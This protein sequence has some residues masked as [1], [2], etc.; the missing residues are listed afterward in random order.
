MCRIIINVFAKFVQ[1]KTKN[2]QTKKKK[3]QQ[4]QECYRCYQTLDMIEKALVFAVKTSSYLILIIAWQTSFKS[5][6][7]AYKQ[8]TM[9]FFLHK[10]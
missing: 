8:I 7:S 4:Q 2:K 9:F 10:V 1:K 6:E 5:I 3:Q